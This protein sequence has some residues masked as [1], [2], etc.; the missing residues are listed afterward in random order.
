M[1]G[2]TLSISEVVEGEYRFGL[3]LC[4]FVGARVHMVPL[5]VEVQMDSKL[6]CRPCSSYAVRMRKPANSGGHNVRK[7]NVETHA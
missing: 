2:T 1:T 3:V 5:I 4:V 7:R 6:T